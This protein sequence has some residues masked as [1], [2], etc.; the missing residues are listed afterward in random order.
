MWDLPGPGIEP[1][2]PVLAGGFLTAG[3]PGKSWL[4]PFKKH[5]KNSGTLRSTHVIFVCASVVDRTVCPKGCAEVLT[6]LP[7]SVALFGNQVFED[8]IEFEVTLDK[9]G[10]NPVTYVLLRTW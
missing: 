6:P 1:M 10:P 8:V 5:L 2:S 4:C 9:K 3:P 7:A